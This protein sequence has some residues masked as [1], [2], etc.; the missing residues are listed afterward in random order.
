MNA[1]LFY[2]NSNDYYVNM[3]V[4]AYKDLQDTNTK[5]PVYCAITK[6]VNTDT[7]VILSTIGINLIELNTELIDNCK[8]IKSQ[9]YKESLDWYKKAFYKLAILATN[10]E[11]AFDKIVYLDTDIQIFKNIDN[12][13]EKPHMSAV[14]NRAPESTLENYQ[15]GRS[16]FCTGLFVWDYK[17]NPGLGDKLLR[18]LNSLDECITWHDQN[19]LNFWYKNWANE[20]ELH[21]SPIYGLMNHADIYNK[22]ED[23]SDLRIIHFVSRDRNS[24]PFLKQTNIP[25]KWCL[26]KE[27]VTHISNNCKYFINNFG[28]RLLPLYPENIKVL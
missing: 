26:L 13:M 11:T 15:L 25:K 3:L 24:W 21:L 10:F 17:N 23:K 2:L 14:I 27:W 1:W 22:L 28:V 12:I 16:N 20:A 8:F 7:R 4:S 5:Y 18:S 6:N 9:K 19:I